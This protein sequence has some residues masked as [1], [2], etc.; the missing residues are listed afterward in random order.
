MVEGIAF[1]HDRRAPMSPLRT[2][3]PIDQQTVVVDGGSVMN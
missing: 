1:A 2:A 3:A